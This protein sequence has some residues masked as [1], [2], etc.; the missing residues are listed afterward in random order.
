MFFAWKMMEVKCNFVLIVGIVKNY[1]YC[2]INSGDA[3]SF[4]S[5]PSFINK[6]NFSA[7]SACPDCAG[8][9]TIA[10]LEEDLPK[11]L[12]R[13]QGG[14]LIT[15]VQVIA[16]TFRCGLCLT[17]FYTPIP[18][19]IKNTS[20]YAPSCASTLVIARYSLG[21]P[22]LRIEQDQSMHGIP[23]KA[24][25]FYHQQYSEPLMQQL[26]I[27]L[28]N[29]LLY[30]QTESNSGLGAAVRYMLRHWTPLTTF[31]RVAGA[32]LDSNWAD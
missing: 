29:Q 20:K 6:R 7:G 21:L 19:S 3:E 8:H 9:N 4:L 11:V 30:E 16:P 13:L 26:F 18:D 14:P 17:R 24:R 27:W 2:C 15:G 32:P 22:M 25:L 5:D 23:L 28:N 10:R 31:L 12:V 1:F